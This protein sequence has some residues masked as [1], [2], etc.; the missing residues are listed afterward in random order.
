LIHFYKRYI[1]FLH[2]PRVGLKKH[3][4]VWPTS[5]KYV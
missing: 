5:S 3:Q 1:S 4:D 2:Q